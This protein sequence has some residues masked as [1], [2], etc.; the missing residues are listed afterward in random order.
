MVELT[1]A[2]EEDSAF[3]LDE[4]DKLLTLDF[5]DPIASA[6]RV[7]DFHQTHP[8]DAVF[9]VDDETALVAA[10]VART[11]GLRHNPVTAV[12]ASGDKA[13]QRVAL[14]EA[15]VPVPL[16]QLH[17]LDGVPP[18][19]GFP[20][21]IKPIA[22]SASRGVIR[23]DN[24]GQLQAD[25]DRLRGILSEALPS[26]PRLCLIE[27][28]I[29]GRE[30]ALEGLLHDGGLQTLALFDKPDP[31]EGPY[32][33]ETIYV[34]PSRAPDGVQGALRECAQA[35]CTALGLE[36]GPVHVELRHNDSG[37]WVIE[38]A[39]RPIG[40]RCGEVLRFGPEGTSLETIL[41]GH[42]LG[43]W[44]T[45]PAREPLAA[46]V[47]MIPVPHAGVFR[48]IRG[49][50]DALATPLVT[51][52]A[53]TAHRGAAVRPLPDEARYLGFIF[54]RASAPD[55]VESALR[56]AWD[57]LEVVVDGD[58]AAGPVP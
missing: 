10:H 32:F 49:V 12:E 57:C 30:Y 44:E 25:L 24:V 50:A 52:L 2:S 34:T 42:A 27:Q 3:S 39:A 37:P 54:A 9:G 36:R 20:A 21:V 18:E 38:L 4:P 51:D 46:G 29:P 13:L 35:A 41:L 55:E 1:V 58:T 53:V 28:Y 19:V 7:L 56:C 43:R 48:E 5:T 14:N 15:G 8:I 33:A 23:V 31:L 47:M 45:A 22:L 17:D 26:E 6:D 40:G 16:F 11:L